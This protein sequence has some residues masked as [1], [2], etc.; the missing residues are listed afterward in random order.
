MKHK[1]AMLSKD[2][3]IVPPPN[4]TSKGFFDSLLDLIRCD[5]FVLIDSILTNPDTLD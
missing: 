4:Y 3:E 1:L 2:Y 5:L